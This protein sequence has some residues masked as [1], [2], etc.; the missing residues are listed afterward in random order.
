VRLRWRAVQV[1]L[2][3][4]NLTAL[5]ITQ[6]EKIV[7]DKRHRA[8]GWE[9]PSVWELHSGW[10]CLEVR[11]FAPQHGGSIVRKGASPT[12]RKTRSIGQR[13]FGGDRW[14]SPPEGGPGLGSGF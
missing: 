13:H 3:M 5:A 2:L 7:S 10:G 12:L 8:S 6:L 9:L 4:A 11:R 1:L 14:A